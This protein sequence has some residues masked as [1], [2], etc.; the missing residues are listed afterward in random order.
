MNIRL[1]IH[2]YNFNKRN[3][4]LYDLKYVVCSFYDK[5]IK[6]KQPGFF[7]IGIPTSSYY[8]FYLRFFQRGDRSHGCA[9]YSFYNLKIPGQSDSNKGLFHLKYSEVMTLSNC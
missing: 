3:K 8:Y 7:R 4:S 2:E 6:V 9:P 1:H 5:A